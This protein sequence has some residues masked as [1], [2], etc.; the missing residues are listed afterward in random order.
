VIKDNSIGGNTNGI[1]VQANAVDNVIRRNAIAGNPPSQV[2]RN[3]G[4]SVGFDVRDEAAL[5]GSGSRNR[6]RQNW[7]V[8]YSGPGP[9]VCPSL[10]ATRESDE[11]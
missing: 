8:T 2:S 11:D 4:T 3:F 9:A 5:V 7:C 10:A 6:F 1:L